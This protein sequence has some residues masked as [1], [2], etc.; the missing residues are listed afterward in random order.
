VVNGEKEAIFN[1]PND[2]LSF[3]GIDL[4]EVS[5]YKIEKLEGKTII[6]IFEPKIVQKTVL[7]IH[8]YFDHTGSFKNIINYFL[9]SNYRVIGYDLEGH[10]LSK[11]NRGEI[12]DF[13]D[14]VQT[15]QKVITFCKERDV[16]P[17]KVIAHSTGAAICTQYLL[18]CRG[19]FEKVIYLAP[20]VR[21][22]NWYYI[23]A[24]SKVV[25]FLKQK[26]TRTFAKNSG[27]DDYLTFVKNDPLQCTYIS[28]PWVLAMINWNKKVEALSPSTQEIYIIQGT[29]DETVEWK[30]NVAFLRKKFPFAQIALVQEG[31]HQI[32]NDSP[33]VKKI[34]FSLIE[35]YR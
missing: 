28:V 5:N 29:L 15:F 26:L 30:Y 21:A 18:Q 1:R 4:G 12:H 33:M 35:K 23:L 8:G 17:N 13:N 24:C 9:S 22:A 7:L 19:R 32:M 20:L 14:Y 11:G 27:D 3:Y 34:V 10:G 31:R 16:Y 6:H 2:Y 25:P